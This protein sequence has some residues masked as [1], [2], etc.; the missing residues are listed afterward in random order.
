MH[1]AIRDA[2]VTRI[3]TDGWT[4]E[5]IGNV[6]MNVAKHGARRTPRN[7]HPRRRR[8]GAGQSLRDCGRLCR[9]GPRSRVRFSRRIRYFNRAA[10]AGCRKSAPRVFPRRVASFLSLSLSLS[11]S[12]P[13]PSSFPRGT[14]LPAEEG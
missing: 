6:L 14:F 9:G 13:P 4:G 8:R 7:I 5:R 2:A 11:L 1:T 3:R 10:L 12:L